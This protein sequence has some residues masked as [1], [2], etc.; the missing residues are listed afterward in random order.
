MSLVNRAQLNSCFSSL[1]RKARG[2]LGRGHK[3]NQWRKY[4]QKRFPF[5]H[6]HTPALMPSQSRGSFH[7]TRC[8]QQR[9]PRIPE[10][11]RNAEFPWGFAWNTLCARTSPEKG[12]HQHPA[13]RF[14]QPDGTAW[15][16]PPSSRPLYLGGLL[17]SLPGCGH[18]IPAGGAGRGTCPAPKEEGQREIRRK[19]YLK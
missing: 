11:I 16:R 6:A 7:R 2:P 8:A 1:S 4:T 15:Q 9:G 12:C 3:S 10:V 13:I 14:P 18:A 17:A 5:P 19:Y